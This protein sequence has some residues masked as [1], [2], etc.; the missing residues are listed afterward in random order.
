MF[1]AVVAIA[2]LV[3]IFLVLRR[4]PVRQ[5]VLIE[6]I[7]RGRELG[8]YVFDYACR[9]CFEENAVPRFSDSPGLS[10]DRHGH[11]PPPFAGGYACYEE[12]PPEASRR[13]DDFEPQEGESAKIV[14]W[15]NLFG[16]IVAY[17][18]ERSN[19]AEEFAEEQLRQY[20]ADLD[21]HFDAWDGIQAEQR[22]MSLEEY[23]RT[24][25]E[26]EIREVASILKISLEEAAATGLSI[27]DA[28]IQ[29]QA[30]R[31]SRK[32][33]KTVTV[34]EV[35]AEYRE[36]L[37]EAA[38]SVPDAGCI[39]FCHK[40]ELEY[41]E[42]GTLSEAWALEH[43]FQCEYCSSCLNEARQDYLSPAGPD[44]FSEDELATIK[45]TGMLPEERLAHSDDCRR[46][47][48][49]FSLL[50]NKHMASLP[51]PEC[52]TQEDLH[53]IHTNGKIPTKCRAH[54]QNCE[55]CRI[56]SVFHLQYYVNRVAPLPQS[57]LMSLRAARRTV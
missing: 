48:F 34:K 40:H 42:T 17:K 5:E 55:R 22:G 31:L 9:R 16:K 11:L 2:I 24:K 41:A 19:F 26:E 18:F 4:V 20:R 23:R 33:G 36:R 53:E 35:L 32:R 15:R 45:T 25:K 28:S 46:C 52:L 38:P 37:H 12:I 3:C 50:R 7:F 8:E 21:L 57:R 56:N 1:S 39:D 14:V 29:A 51:G 49:R 13:K 54:I 30:Q 47:N 44:C 10:L 43:F 27:F 6:G